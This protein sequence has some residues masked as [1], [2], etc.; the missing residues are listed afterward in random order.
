MSTNHFFHFLRT[1]NRSKF[2]VWLGDIPL[3]YL[4]KAPEIAILWH[5][6]L[7]CRLILRSLFGFFQATFFFLSNHFSVSEDIFWWLFT[8]WEP[9]A[10]EDVEGEDILTAGSLRVLR[11]MEEGLG[12]E[13]GGTVEF[14][15]SFTGWMDFWRLFDGN[16]V[17]FFVFDFFAGCF[18]RW[19]NSELRCK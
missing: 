17:F 10:L 5:K 13:Q 18:E 19:Q 4:N 8:R 7:G 14:L 11:T 1:K 16:D 12:T 3:G 6:K 9:Q 15:F 2:Q